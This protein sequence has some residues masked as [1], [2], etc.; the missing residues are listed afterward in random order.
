MN[1]NNINNPIGPDRPV[2]SKRDT[3]RIT[4][5][6]TEQFQET[7]E[8][9]KLATE[10]EEA[11]QS[12][13]DTFQIYKEP[14][15]VKELTRDVENM[16]ETPREDAVAR[17]RERVSKGYYNNEEVMGRVALRLINIEPP[18]D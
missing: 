7:E 5:E 4:P 11:E 18:A 15:F 10:T 17:A 9:P 13:R 8:T 14:K 6:R 3:A 2:D 16:K 12:A 1:I